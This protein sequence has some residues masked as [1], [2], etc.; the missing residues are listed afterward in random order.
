MNTHTP[1]AS[2]PPKLSILGINFNQDQGCFAVAHESGFLVFNTNPI[3]LRVERNFTAPLGIAH[4]TMLHRTNYLALIGG[5]LN[6]KFSPHKLIIWDDLKRK[7]SLFLE[8]DSPVLNVLLSRIRIVVVLDSQVLLYSFTSP[9][10]RINTYNISN[11]YGLADLSSTNEDDSTLLA[12]PGRQLGQIQLVDVSTKGQQNNIVSIIKAHKSAIRCLALN[13]TGTLIAS[14]SEQG[15]LIRIHSTK[16]TALLHEFRRGIDKAIIF[17][18]KFNFDDSR[19]A[20]LL[21]KNTLHVFNIFEGKDQVIANRKHYL[22]KL[23]IPIP[24]PAYFN[25]TWSFCSINTNIYHS[26]NDLSD[27]GTIGWSGKD[28]IIVVWKNR[29]IWEKYTIARV[30]NN[31]T[32]S[33]GSSSNST[34]WELSRSSW[35]T[36]ES[37]TCDPN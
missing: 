27:Q 2:T 36:L 1:L 33:A 15:T 21:D 32:E 18:M 9:P 10:K 35:K 22:K 7:T 14:A 31:T 16:N 17:S 6:P 19:L 8:F 4:I 24:I 37:L 3:E 13:R 23:N 34:T 30:N 26:Q 20:V 28:S 11:P 5:G 12:F 25:S 29:K